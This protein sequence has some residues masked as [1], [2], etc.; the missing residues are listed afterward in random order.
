VTTYSYDGI[1]QFDTIAVTGTYDI[2]AD[3]SQGTPAIA[4]PGSIGPPGGL[5]ASVS[6]DIVLQQGAV[7][8]IVVGGQGSAAVNGGGGGGGGS[9]VIEIKNGSGSTV[10][11]NEVIA[12]GGGGGGFRSDGT[13]NLG[14]R[15]TGT[16]GNGEGFS[17]GAGGVNGAPGTGGFTGGGGGGFEGGA[18]AYNVRAASGS[19]ALGNFAGG[20]ASAPSGGGR[21]AGGG[22][23]GGG[24]GGG[25]GGGG[26]GGGFGGGGGG[27]AIFAAGNSTGGGG[28]GSFIAAGA[29]NFTKTAGNHHG[30]GVV[31]I[32]LAVLCFC[33][34]SMILTPG[35]EVKVEHLS[36]GDS[37]V[38]LGGAE[39]PIV[40]IGKGK[41]LTTRG[42]RGPATPIVFRKGALADNVPNQDLHVTKG[43][44]FYIDNVLIP[45][46]F[47]V[48]HKSIFWDDRAQE[49]EIYHIELATHDVL[50]ANGAP[51]ESYRDDGN[52]WLFQNANDG[53]DQPGKRPYA[54]VLTGGPVVDEIWHRLLERAGG[55]S[56]VPTTEDSDLH[57]LVDGV[58][59]DAMARKAGRYVFR[60]SA[61]PERVRIVSRNTVPSELGFARD[62]R[63]LGV[64][65]RK[66]TLRQGWRLRWIDPDDDRLVDGFHAYEAGDNIRWTN[67]DAALPDGAFVNFGK[68]AIVELHL[69]GATTY[70]LFEAAEQ[71]VMLD[72]AVHAA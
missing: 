56:A 49:V 25:T 26:G 3:G 52:R 63:S 6:G 28:G 50:F 53:W 38:T 61:R 39:R 58:R 70:P 4:P 68:D 27:G 18:G 31:T 20:A 29:T 24:G 9:F 42:K 14:G 62:P 7:L 72:R 69:G 2:T 67:G 66:V 44:S 17:A 30:V 11:I 13:G 19:S 43:H 37:I 34:G 22:G 60:L 35:G 15:T 40:W 5:G 8:E 12:G 21:T 65:L 16:G 64:A 10:D 1:I 32:A 59:L 55:G 45:A 33:P 51:A 57:L 36:V 46:E 71:A 47:L 23:F 48:N 41:V 54:P